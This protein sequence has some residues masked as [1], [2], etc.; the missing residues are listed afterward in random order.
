MKIFTITASETAVYEHKIEAETREEA[1]QQ[2]YECMEWLEPMDYLGFQIDG[3]QTE[4][5]K[6]AIN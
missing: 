2:F 6:N 5:I 4:E 3:V 1:M